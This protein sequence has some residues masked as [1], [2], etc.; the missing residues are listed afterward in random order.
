ME[1]SEISN[2]VSA[3]NSWDICQQYPA[4]KHVYKNQST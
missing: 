2:M 3:A 1:V 4:I